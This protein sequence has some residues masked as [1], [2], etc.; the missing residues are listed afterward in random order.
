MLGT[1]ADPVAAV[2]EASVR[3]LLASVGPDGEAPFRR[4]QVY[5]FHARSASR[6]RDRSVFLAG[7]AAHLTPPF[8]GQGMNSGLRDAFNL[9]WKLTEAL[10]SP[11]PEPLLASY[12]TE[13]KPHAWS[14]IMLALRMGRIMMPTSR[15]QGAIVRGAFHALGLYPPARDYFAQMRYKP[16][17]RFE[18]GLIWPDGKPKSQSVVGQ[19]FPQ[20]EVEDPDRLRMLL[21]EFLPDSPVLVVYAA[22]PEQSISETLRTRFDA[23][24]VAVV[25][26]TPEWNNPATADFPIA[27]DR[28][29][30]LSAKPFAGYLNHVLLLRRDRYVAGAAPCAKAEG[31]LDFARV[32]CPSRGRGQAP[33]SKSAAPAH[34]VKETV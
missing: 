1:D 8:A 5:T 4:V 11:N 32:L 15:L 12:E 29:R 10:A 34:R 2:E 31:L 24:G 3:K 20:P 22:A 17:P 13:R 16:K 26:V 18:Q 25:G 21:D 33:A 14:L 28:S 6:W 23:A 30:W 9:A 27:R 19:M 7:D